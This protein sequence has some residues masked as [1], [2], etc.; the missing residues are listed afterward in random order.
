MNN[1]GKAPLY[2]YALD[3]SASKLSY[4]ILSTILP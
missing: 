4:P 2:P 3:D 1:P